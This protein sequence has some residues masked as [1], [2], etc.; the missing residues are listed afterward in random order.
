MAKEEGEDSVR[1]TRVI[2][3]I[4]HTELAST[5]P[6]ATKDFLEQVFSWKFQNLPSP[7]GELI[8]YQTP[9][10]AQG[11][12]R[13]TRPEELPMSLNYVLVRDLGEAERKIK[14]HG[15]EIVLPRVDVPDMGGFF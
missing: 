5:N 8:S 10:G 1:L 14:M 3:M 2:G 15:G 13:K 11:S 4:A 9:G 12:I 6:G 7:Q